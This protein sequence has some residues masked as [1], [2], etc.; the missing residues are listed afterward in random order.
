MACI[1]DI[2]NNNSKVHLQPQSYAAAASKR[3]IENEISRPNR[4]QS[5]PRRQFPARQDVPNRA[6][7]PH[8][9]MYRNDS[10]QTRSSICYFCGNDGHIVRFCPHVC[11]TCGKPGH[12]ISRCFY[13]HTN[14]PNR[15]PTRRHVHRVREADDSEEWNDNETV[16][17]Q[18]TLSDES[19]V[20]RAERKTTTA[21]IHA[22]TI[23]N[24]GSKSKKSHSNKNEKTQTSKSRHRRYPEEIILLSDYIEGKI[25]QYPKAKTL[26]S[27][28]NPEKAVNKPIVAG[29]CNG[30]DEKL[31]CDTGA[32]INVID[33]RHF[34]RIQKNGRPLKLYK[35]G[36]VIRCANNSKMNVIGWT[37]INIEIGNSNRLCKLWVVPDLFPKVILGIRALKD[38]NVK[39]DPPN[40]CVEVDGE[41]IKFLSKTNTESESP[42]P[43]VN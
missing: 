27:T 15:N 20:L 29:K 30:K 21:E 40:D 24:L 23:H 43:L 17:T 2:L 28:S 41:R 18:S 31:F 12:E 19:P 10:R 37:R 22:M 4:N 33:E 6:T 3:P 26:I 34:R 7:Q 38:L 36:K 35:A 42:N 11:G 39:I 9:G 32:E 8:A 1:V 25:S 13:N 16:D 14:R 5:A